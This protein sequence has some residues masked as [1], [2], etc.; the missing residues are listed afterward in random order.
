MPQL[1]IPPDLNPNDQM[2]LPQVTSQRQNERG[3]VVLIDPFS[4]NSEVWY[5]PLSNTPGQDSISVSKIGTYPPKQAIGDWTRSNHE[6]LSFYVESDTS[7]GGQVLEANEAI[8]E[9]RYWWATV[10][11]IWPRQIVLLPYA[12]EV[13][14]PEGAVQSI[15]L[16]DYNGGV[17]V[18][19][20]QQLASVSTSG[21]VTPLATLP[22][23]IM[24]RRGTRFRGTS[25]GV[26]M[27]IPMGAN[28]YCVWDGAN[29]TTV[30]D[31]HP[32]DMMEFDAKL[33]AL[34]QDGTLYESLDGFTDWQGKAT[35]DGAQTMRWLVNFYN[36]SDE[37]TIHI[38][39][40]TAIYGVDL[41]V[42][43]AYRT[44]VDPPVHPDAALDGAVWRTDLYVSYG[45]GVH[46]YTGNSILATGLDRDHGIPQDYSGSIVSMIGGYNGLYAL[47]RGR[48]TD[49]ETEAFVSDLG[50]HDVSFRAS[51][52]NSA[53]MMWNAYGW[54]PVWTS[55]G[56]DGISTNILISNVNGTY[57]LWWG[58]GGSLFYI[59]LGYMYH[60]PEQRDAGIAFAQHGSIEYPRLDMAITG[61]DKLFV[62][63]ELRVK[64]TSPTERVSVDVSFDN[65]PWTELGVIDYQPVDRKSVLMKFG[66]NGNYPGTTEPR[67]DGI[68]ADSIQVRV[69]LERG[70]DRFKTPI[71]E[72]MG[73]VFHKL[74]G[75]LNAYQFLVDNT[76][77]DFYK[78]KTAQ[79]RKEFLDRMIPGEKLVPFLHEGKWRSVRFA[80]ANGN[81][82]TGVDLKGDRSVSLLEVLDE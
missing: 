9:N 75:Q 39:T 26:K 19:F 80:G 77:V 15:V 4:P 14:G 25:G 81:D 41:Q 22:H 69:N 32:V 63:V 71:L 52:A 35:I 65:G 29:L 45:M 24:L 43:K 72:S 54:H 73:I 51:A 47:V 13:K 40:D 48:Q 36:A 55:D 53:V 5:L 57:R 61:K 17:L 27:F 21:V 78:G 1:P 7:G 44:K 79:Q 42:G 20:D 10:A 62:G 56:Q 82:L 16:G 67:Y 76:T 46:Q 68:S 8:H 70:S 33:Y 34:D 50:A 38:G 3:E 59:D 66:L 37:P 12:T 60:N 18:A 74:M 11:T 49:L 58:Y 23:P 31:I 6:V 28:G 64:D 30:T 2:H